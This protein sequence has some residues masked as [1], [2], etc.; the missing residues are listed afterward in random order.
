MSKKND[1]I[2]NVI[3]KLKALKKKLLDLKKNML[4]DYTYLFFFFW[5]VYFYFIL[6]FLYE[7][8]Y[9]LTIFSKTLSY[10]IVYVL[11]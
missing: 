11:S 7:R 2:K 3:N 5:C 9:V 10:S 4:V 6:F 8:E 1:I